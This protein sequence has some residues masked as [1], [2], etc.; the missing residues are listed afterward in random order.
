MS[1]LE[2]LVTVHPDGTMTRRTLSP[3]ESAKLD[4]Q[5]FEKFDPV[6]LES[7]ALQEWRKKRAQASM[8]STPDASKGVQ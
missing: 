7:R 1:K 6:T 5:F 2:E 4:K 8:P 3:E